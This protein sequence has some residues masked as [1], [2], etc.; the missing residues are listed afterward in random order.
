MR[1]CPAGSPLSGAEPDYDPGLWNDRTD[2]RTSHN[3]FS[4]A[5]NIQ[6]PRQLE[7]C[8]DPNES[9]DAPF[10]QPGFVSG[11]SRFGSR[12]PKTCPNMIIRMQGDNPSVKRTTFEEKCPAGTSKIAIIVD[13]NEDFHFLRQDSNMF[14][15][16][17]PG[18]RHVINHDA[19]KHLI[20]NPELADYNWARSDPTTTLNY[21]VFCGYMCVPRNR[22]LYIKAGGGFPPSPSR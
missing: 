7:D 5:M 13:E 20:W 4:Y 11:F 8:E 1:Y 9:C 10:H 6:D 17:K 22:P 18:G 15:S 19:G 2:I 3:C 21:D 12:D 14:W 16:H